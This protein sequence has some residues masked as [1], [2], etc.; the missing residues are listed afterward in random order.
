[1]HERR[2]WYTRRNGVVRGPYP[3]TQISRYILLGRIRATDEVC[4]EGGHWTSLGQRADLI[5]EVM[6]LPPSEENRQKLFM[7][8]LREDERRPRDRREQTEAASAATHERRSGPDRRRAESAEVLRARQLRAPAG[9]RHGTRYRY[10]LGIA[11]LAVFGLLLGFLYATDRFPSPQPE[12]SPPAR[13]SV[14]GKGCNLTGLEAQ[15]AGL[16]A[17]Q[18]RNTPLDA[19]ELSGASLPLVGAGSRTR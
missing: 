5:P 10:P 18:M 1:M 8:R 11:L 4:S 2:L 19:A 7:A 13:P 3:E 17:A 14:V 6:K 12:C 9:R 15:Q 16:A